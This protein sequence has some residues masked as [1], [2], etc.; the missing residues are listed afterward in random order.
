MWLAPTTV[1]REMR[2]AVYQFLQLQRYLHKCR[3]SLKVSY[4]VVADG[5]DDGGP[6]GLNVLCLSSWQP[7]LLKEKSRM[8][9]TRE[10]WSSSSSGP[11]QMRLRKG[12]ATSFIYATVQ[13]AFNQLDIV[14]L[15]VVQLDIFQIFEANVGESVGARLEF[16][17]KKRKR[18]VGQPQSL[19]VRQAALRQLRCIISL[20][21]KCLHSAESAHCPHKISESSKKSRH[22]NC[23][24]SWC[25][26]YPPHTHPP[27]NQRIS[28]GS[29]A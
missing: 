22:R 28:Q 27:K 29:L 24:I 14:Q 23:A 2:T 7:L 17:Y 3:P 4:L 12:K 25:D 19:S 10:C 9:T 11:K 18:W 15:D 21:I 1:R 5:D 26:R 20:E 13:P 6:D 16:L 8:R